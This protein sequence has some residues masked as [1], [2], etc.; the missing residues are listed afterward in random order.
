MISNRVDELLSLWEAGREAGQPVS[1]EELCADDPELLQEVRWTIHALE[2]VESQFGFSASEAA[3][4]GTPADQSAI[5]V[6]V[7]RVDVRSRYEVERL[8]ARGG[9][10]RV[11]VALDR[12]LNRRV[13]I[14]FPVSSFLTPEARARFRREADVTSRLDHPGI[15]PVHA[16]DDGDEVRPPCYVM[17]FVEGQTLHEAIERSAKSANSGNAVRQSTARAAATDTDPASPPP[18]SPKTTAPVTPLELPDLLQRFVTVCNIVAFAHSR[19]V[20][21]RDIKPANILLGDFGETLVLDWGLARYNG[22]PVCTPQSTPHAPREAAIAEPA[23]EEGSSG[24]ATS[25]TAH[26]AERDEYNEHNEH[27]S[28]HTHSGQLLGTP[29]YASPEQLLGRTGEIDERSDVYS[30]GATLFRILTGESV[31]RPNDPAARNDLAGHLEQIRSGALHGLADR[32]RSVPR[33]LSAICRKALSV[34]SNGRYQSALEL[35]SDVEHFLRDEPI[36]IRCESVPEIAVRWLRK[37]PRTTSGIVASLAVGFTAA[38]VSSL[39]LNQKNEQLDGVNLRL[40]DSN[41]KLAAAVSDSAASRD[42]AVSAL[43]SLS[44]DVLASFLRQKRRLTGHQTTYLQR[45]LEHYD[46][47]ARS[48]DDTAEARLLKTEGLVQCGTIHLALRDVANAEPELQEAIQLLIVLSRESADRLIPRRLVTAHL[49]LADCYSIQR[50]YDL[51]AGPLESATSIIVD[52]LL[53]KQPD[54][55][56]ALLFQAQ[57]LER[58]AQNERMLGRQ[59]KALE[60]GREAESVLE[61]LVASGRSDSEV[62]LTLATVVSGMEQSLAEGNQDERAAEYAAHA[63]QL[64]VKLFEQHPTDPDC[65]NGLA[66]SE[67]RIASAFTRVAQYGDAID[68]CSRGIALAD[69][70]V[71]EFPSVPEYRLTLARLLQIRGSARRLMYERSAAAADL[72][73]AFEIARLL[74]AEN[75]DEPRD[76]FQSFWIR[77]QALIGFELAEDRLGFD[78]LGKQLIV[79]L[80]LAIPQMEERFQPEFT[81]LLGQA[82]LVHGALLRSLDRF[83]DAKSELRESITMLE[84]LTKTPT[85]LQSY[86][87]DLKDAYCHLAKVYRDSGEL[88]QAEP[89]FKLARAMIQKRWPNGGHD[90]PSFYAMASLESD[91]GLLLDNQERHLEAEAAFQTEISLRK[92]ILELSPRFRQQIT[93]LGGAHCNLGNALESQSRLDE[94]LA[95]FEQ[96][97]RL[98]TDNLAINPQDSTTT[99]FLR[100]SRMGRAGT[101]R[102]QSRF[103]EALTEFNAVR[104][105][106]P[107]NFNAALRTNRADCLARVSPAE[108]VAEAKTIQPNSGDKTYSRIA[109]VSVFA[110]AAE[111]SNDATVIAD[112]KANAMKQLKLLESEGG[113]RLKLNQN[114]LKVSADLNSLRELPEFKELLARVPGANEPGTGETPPDDASQ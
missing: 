33:P 48:T 104:D 51:V 31:F 75:F 68:A 47:F 44:D 19:G 8:H 66:R 85:G 7:T 114:R 53:A 83:S 110:I 98:L 71:V 76:V 42:R 25:D 10:G 58:L 82:L 103:Q 96:A 105:V 59:S 23:T 88:D 36:S 14:K 113:F 6:P 65:Q 64:W 87:G 37:H 69:K 15:V 43:R 84:P 93:L 20:I 70:A 109:V 12:Q 16:I 30:L 21:H 24:K 55:H 49:K 63:K 100:N 9:L 18:E 101:F 107:K 41:D 22:E 35:G 108:A 99:L 39:L 2:K 54:D 112:A 34:A 5:D 106:S 89:H 32:L 40:S 74:P 11:F 80:R 17:R 60:I 86:G 4:D 27:R 95:E 67:F 45:V 61:T 62:I 97:I 91:W 94:A 78:Q 79:D 81:Q 90:V 50:K 77:L 57:T 92:K 72:N 111:N 1:A 28:F 73:R 26:H 38:L 102:R 46:A 3:V 56:A 13:A 52:Q 29:S